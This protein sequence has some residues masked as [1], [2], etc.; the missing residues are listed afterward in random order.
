MS[1]T[2]TFPQSRFAPPLGATE[3]LLVRHGESA[4]HVDGEAEP[5]EAAA[6]AAVSEL[7]GPRMF[8]VPIRLNEQDWYVVLYDNFTSRAGAEEA[9][10]RFA[11][12]FPRASAWVRDASQLRKLVRYR[13]SEPAM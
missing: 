8:I 4:P 10:R 11:Q 6:K 9:A 7:G 2:R 12:E 1:E 13:P 3:I 5:V